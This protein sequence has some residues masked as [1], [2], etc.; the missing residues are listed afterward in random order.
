MFAVRRV[1]A[2]GFF[3]WRRLAFRERAAVVDGVRRSVLRHGRQ[4]GQQP[5][6]LS[7]TDFATTDLEPEAAKPQDSGRFNQLIFGACKFESNLSIF[8]IVFFTIV[9]FHLAFKFCN[10]FLMH[11]L[12]ITNWDLYLVI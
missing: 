8:T 10:A 11:L 12:C 9:I 3:S 5:Q 4:P 1:S 7:G 6:V 2:L